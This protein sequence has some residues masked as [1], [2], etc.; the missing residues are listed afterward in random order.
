MAA[1]P[2][3]S[4]QLPHTATAAAAQTVNM[5]KQEEAF[6]I[7]ATMAAKPATSA[8]LPH[9]ATAA[10]PAQYTVFRGVLLG[11]IL[12]KCSGM[13]SNQPPFAPKSSFRSSGSGS[14]SCC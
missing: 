12:N 9:N 1:K 5:I 14:S 13:V 2:A 3:T 6:T 10:A 7:Q 4:A 8:Q 11:K